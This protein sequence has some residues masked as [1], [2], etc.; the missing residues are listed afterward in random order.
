VAQLFR[1]AT[2]ILVGG[3]FLLGCMASTFAQNTVFV[4]PTKN[5]ILVRTKHDQLQI[6]ACGP[7]VLHIIGGVDTP[8]PSAEHAPWII[9]PCADNQFALTKEGKFAILSTSQLRVGIALDSGALTFSDNAGNELLSEDRA[10]AR[11]YEALGRPQ[12]HLYRISERFALP[13]DEALYGLGQHQ[14]GLLDYRGT[15]TILSQLNTDI[16]VPFLVSTRGYAL[17]WNTAARCVVDNGFPKLL[18]VTAAAGEGLDFYFLYGPE[19]DRLIHHYRNLT[20]RAPL[21]GE[22]AYGFFQSKDRYTSQDQLVRIVGRYRSEQIPLDTIV[23]DGLWWTIRGSSQFNSGFPDFVSAVERIHHDHAHVMISIWPRFDKGTAI[24]QQ[25]DAHGYLLQGSTN[26]D[27]T[28]PGARDLYWNMLPRTLLERGA[29]AFWM[30]ASEPEQRHLDGG[31]LPN[32]QL[33]LGSSDLFTNIFPLYHSYGM[34]QHWRETFEQKRV[35]ILTRCSFLGQQHYAAAVWSGDV[36]SNFWALKRQIPAG[37]N[38]ALSGMPYWT[39]DIGGYSDP[40][41]DTTDPKYQ[42]LYT[43]WFEYGTFCPIFRTHGSRVNDQNELWSYGAATPTL[44]KFDKF[45]YRL[46][47][48][49]YSLAWQVTNDDYTIMRPLVMDWRTDRRVWG[50]GDEFMFGPALLVNP[51]TEAGTTSRSVYL[52]SAAAWYDFWTGERLEGGQSIQ[53]SAPVERIPLYIRAGSILPLG[54][55]IQYAGDK[56]ADPIELRIYRGVDASFD[57][58]EDEGENYNYEKGAHAVIPI[59]WSEST[60][61]LT[62]G[63]RIGQFPGMLQQ[64]TFRI[65]WVGPNQGA[66]PKVVARADR[67]VQYNG[68]SMTIAA[69]NP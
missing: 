19:F 8:K 11:S 25:M 65:V 57:L 59:R 34:Y 37:L 21:F 16:A 58:Y 2:E 48:Y 32:Q 64:R 41:G 1:R 7:S 38:F 63:D 27:A 4:T 67:E 35:F 52:P 6:S 15:S 12:D 45:R 17:M 31:I 22:W 43:R 36:Y 51:V 54:P 29:D 26:Y 23:L 24:R 68:Q 40:D 69:P 60:K 30:D 53:A 39:T 66:G 56:P 5:G 61:T 18:S 13:V 44:V 49:I 3:I 55:D 62:M 9:I 47:P 33:Y 46:L 28:N 10:Q 42:E 50:I 14:S 20:G